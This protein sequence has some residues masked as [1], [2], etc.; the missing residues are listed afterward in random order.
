M[1]HKIL[2]ESYIPFQCLIISSLSKLNLEGVASS[3]YYLLDILATQG[4]KTTKEL[5]EIRGISQSG[6]SKLTK[7]LLDKGYIVQ[8]RSAEDRRCYHIVITES[9][10][11]FLSKSATLRNEMLNAIENALSQDEVKTFAAL[12]KKI[13]EKQP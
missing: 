7:R 9:G 12:C 11:S 13:S 2:E 4:E 1:S 8:K 3:Q 6:I 10:K 5:A